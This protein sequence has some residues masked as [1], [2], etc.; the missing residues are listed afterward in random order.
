MT[1]EG[2]SPLAEA[3]DRK[4]IDGLDA[5]GAAIYGLIAAGAGAIPEWV[6]KVTLLLVRNYLLS[7][8]MWV[9][10]ERQTVAAREAHA[11]LILGVIPKLCAHGLFGMNG[12]AQPVSLLYRHGE[13]YPVVAMATAL[14]DVAADDE[15]AVRVRLDQLAFEWLVRALDFE[16]RPPRKIQAAD[17]IPHLLAGLFADQIRTAPKGRAWIV[18]G[19]AAAALWLQ[20]RPEIAEVPDRSGFYRARSG[21]VLG[22]PFDLY[23]NTALPDF[24]AVA[25]YQEDEADAAAGFAYYQLSP[26]MPL[27]PHKGL[28]VRHAGKLFDAN[29]F[30]AFEVE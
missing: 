29:A 28:R 3:G 30:Q 16:A 9:E 1:M 7:D 20:T 19:K 25:G 6:R 8:R 4:E 21:L 26:A 27:S 5:D 13:G 12:M 14:S 22:R 2:N 17:V 24:V 18:A 23:V 11:R 10:S 15:E